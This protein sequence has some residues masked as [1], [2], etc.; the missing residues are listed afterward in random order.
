MFGPLISLEFLNYVFNAEIIMLNAEIII[1]MIKRKRKTYW[2]YM[3][4]DFNILRVS[5]FLLRN[6]SV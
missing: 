2:V 5:T 1:M 3:S 4:E 6:Y